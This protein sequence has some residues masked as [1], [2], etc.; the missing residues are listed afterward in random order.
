MGPFRLPNRILAW[1]YKTNAKGWLS[2][3]LNV[4]TL[5]GIPMPTQIK[6]VYDLELIHR[7]MVTKCR[8]ECKDAAGHMSKLETYV[9]VCDFCEIGL[10]VSPISIEPTE[11]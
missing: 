9:R 3:V 6:F 7:K 5:T 4:C 2:D 10:L 1:N 11:I 8:D